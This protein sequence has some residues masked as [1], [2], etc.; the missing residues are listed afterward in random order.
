V[1]S[2]YFR[3]QKDDLLE[4]EKVQAGVAE[5]RL[6]WGTGGATFAGSAVPGNPPSM[7]LTQRSPATAEGWRDI[8]ISVGV[9]N[10]WTA[11]YRLPWRMVGLTVKMVEDE[12]RFA[13]A[14]VEEDLPAGGKGLQKDKRLFIAGM[15]YSA[16]PQL[17][18]FQA[19]MAEKEGEIL[20]KVFAGEPETITAF[21]TQYEVKFTEVPGE[22]AVL[23]QV[24]PGSR[25]WNAGLR[26][27]DVVTRLAGVSTR[28]PALNLAALLNRP[29]TFEI[30]RRA[31]VE[32]VRIS[33]D[34]G[35][36]LKFLDF[37]EK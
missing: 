16:N 10:E 11:T 29:V 12:P 22:Y 13:V 8:R 14:Q 7:K 1:L 26:P 30:Y 9:L 28:R 27:G 18:D 37:R 31:Q 33:R 3:A 2:S 6:N 5:Y 36:R 34:V 21:V 19:A 32:E 15:R 20:L 23:K 35:M 4:L 25:A 17:S 24:G